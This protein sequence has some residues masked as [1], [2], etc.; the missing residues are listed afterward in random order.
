LPRNFCRLLGLGSPKQAFA[1]IVARLRVLETYPQNQQAKKGLKAL[2]KGEVNK[3]NPSSPPQA[4][5]DAVIS[6]YSQGQVQ[7]ALRASETLIKDYPNNPQY[8]R[9][10]LSGTRTTGGSG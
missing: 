8:Y 5:I 3:K 1:K 7:E 6:L 4:Q 9:R 10:L 2:Q